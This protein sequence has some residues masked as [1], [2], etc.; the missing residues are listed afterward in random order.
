[1][2]IEVANNRYMGLGY[3][4]E[5]YSARATKMTIINSQAMLLSFRLLSHGSDGINEA[6]YLIVRCDAN[7]EITG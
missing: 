2:V 4:I 1:M 7:C 6:G 5:G 3:V